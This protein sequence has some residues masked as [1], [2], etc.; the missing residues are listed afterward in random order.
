MSPARTSAEVLEQIGVT[1]ARLLD[2]PRPGFAEARRRLIRCYATRVLGIGV[3]EASAPTCKRG[4]AMTLTDLF[5]FDHEAG[6]DPATTVALERFRALGLELGARVE[7][8]E[9]RACDEAEARF[10]R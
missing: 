2:D 1:V 6:D 4:H 9:C 3:R 7:L 10:T 8:Y 5:R